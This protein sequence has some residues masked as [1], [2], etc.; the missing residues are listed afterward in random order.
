VGRRS[1]EDTNKARLSAGRAPLPVKKRA[2]NAILPESKKKR[3]QE[4]LATMLSRKGKAVVEKV[5]EK[6]LDDDDSDQLAC[7][8]IVMDRI[9]PADYLA[10]NKGKGGA[11]QINISGVGIPEVSSKEVEDDGVIEA[12]YEEQDGTQT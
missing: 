5:M 7:L 6:A 1:N 11:I 8:K 10:K 2:S 4:I 12:E 3:N 9:L